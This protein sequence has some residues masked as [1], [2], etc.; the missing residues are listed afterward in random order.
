MSALRCGPLL[1]GQRSLL[2]QTWPASALSE[3]T[4]KGKPGKEVSWR[5]HYIRTVP[6]FVIV[7]QHYQRFTIHGF[8]SIA[9]SI[10]DIASGS[11][12]YKPNSTM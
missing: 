8:E 9:K 2:C 3:R 1:R 4:A 11:K 10:P 12:G 6:C 7:E 5:D